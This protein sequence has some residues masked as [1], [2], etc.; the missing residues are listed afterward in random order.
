MTT[1]SSHA[2]GLDKVYLDAL[3]IRNIQKNQIWPLKQEVYN[4]LREL[5]P[6]MTDDQA[7]HWANEIC[8]DC[9]TAE[10]MKTIKLVDNMY[11]AKL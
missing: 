3:A 1:A 8:F 11:S 9:M 10:I 6:H 4:S 7:E 5:Y 2:K